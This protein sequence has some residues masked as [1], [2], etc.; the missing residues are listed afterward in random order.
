MRPDAHNPPMPPPIGY[1]MTMS[2]M[3]R[4]R[5]FLFENSATTALVQESMPPMPR[6]VMMRQMDSWTGLPAVVAMNMPKAIVT[7][8]PSSVGRRPMRSAS[9]P[10]NTEPTAMPISSIER[11][12]PSA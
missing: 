8:H 11:T 1:P 12:M 4:L 6:P 9:P 2:E 10:K 5:H 3:Q 7:R